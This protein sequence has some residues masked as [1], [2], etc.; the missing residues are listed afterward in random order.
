M[1]I[2][3]VEDISKL[4]GISPRRVRA[5]AQHRGVGNKVPGSRGGIWVFEQS[6]VEKLRPGPNGRP[7]KQEDKC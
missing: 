7:K 6:D 1:D 3:S 4:L 5:I 2:L